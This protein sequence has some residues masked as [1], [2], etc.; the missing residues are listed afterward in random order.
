M[1]S[2]VD[3]I[4]WILVGRW[5]LI[6]PTCIQRRASLINYIG[7]WNQVCVLMSVLADHFIFSV[8]HAFIDSHS[9]YHSKSK[10]T[11]NLK[12]K[13][14]RTKQEQV[15]KEEFRH[16][17]NQQINQIKFSQTSYDPGK[18]LYLSYISRA[19]IINFKVFLKLWHDTHVSGGWLLT[20]L[21]WHLYRIHFPSEVPFGKLHSSDPRVL[22][23]GFCCVNQS[24]PVRDGKKGFPLVRFW[25]DSNIKQSSFWKENGPESGC[26]WSRLQVLSL[27]QRR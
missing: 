4:K 3:K 15:N 5:D 21:P 20:S 24:V 26:L 1:Q 27:D 13:V 18:G 14:D 2:L 12:L 10:D 17:S 25:N 9:G 11:Y 23:K 22:R 16:K 8:I 6:P 7:P 19:D